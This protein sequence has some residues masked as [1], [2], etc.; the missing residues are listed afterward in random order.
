LIGEHNQLDAELYRHACALFEQRL[1]EAG[2]DVLSEVE[3]VRTASKAAN[4][5]DH[6]EVQAAADW[7]EG[8]LPPGPVALSDTLRETARRTGLSENQLRRALRLV[9]D[10]RTAPESPS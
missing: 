1:A 3:A 4:E 9:K 5:K 10:R 7:L 8:E 2:E 6:A